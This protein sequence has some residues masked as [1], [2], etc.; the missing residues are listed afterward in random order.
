VLDCRR[1]TQQRRRK[2]YT[3]YRVLEDEKVGREGTGNKEQG[4][5]GNRLIIFPGAEDYKCFS[6][7]NT[8]VKALFGKRSCFLAVPDVLIRFCEAVAIIITIN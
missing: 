1:F 3:A 8:N 6:W 2:S 7:R 4:Y 5:K